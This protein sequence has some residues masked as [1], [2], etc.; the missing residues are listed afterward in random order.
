MRFIF[1]ENILAK[2][3]EHISNF[4]EFLDLIQKYIIFLE[5]LSY[6]TLTLIQTLILTL[7]IY[8]AC[9]SSKMFVK[10]LLVIDIKALTFLTQ[11]LFL[12]YDHIWKIFFFVCFFLMSSL[13]ESGINDRLYYAKWS[14]DPEALMLKKSTWKV[15]EP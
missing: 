3:L 4:L 11:Y 2:I 8:A 12:Q 13:C 1:L 15:N 10:L 5:Y 6:F 7:H 14:F 9:F